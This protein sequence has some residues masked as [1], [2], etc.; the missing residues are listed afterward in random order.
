MVLRSW[1]WA[2]QLKLRGPK[3]DRCV[4]GLGLLFPMKNSPWCLSP[5]KI[6]DVPLPFPWSGSLL[7]TFPSFLVSAYFFLLCCEE[8]K[9]SLF[10]V[11]LMALFSPVFLLFDWL[12]C[13]PESWQHGPKVLLTDD[14]H[15]QPLGLTWRVLLLRKKVGSCLQTAYMQ[16]RF[17]SSPYF[18]LPTWYY[19]K[20]LSCLHAYAYVC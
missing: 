8:K 7:T 10:L 12:L 11:L 1:W 14:E 9:K 18:H 15:V 20:E 13:E 6:T 2:L 16:Q 4:Q 17:Q 19:V 5:C 3:N